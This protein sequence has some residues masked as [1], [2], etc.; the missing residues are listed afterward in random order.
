MSIFARPIVAPRRSPIASIWAIRPFFSWSSAPDFAQR[1]F[2]IGPTFVAWPA[3]IPRTVSALPFAF[4]LRETLARRRLVDPGRQHFQI[5]Q[6]L[7]LY[8][9]V[10]HDCFLRQAAE[11]VM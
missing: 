2:S 3:F 5:D 8:R 11:I 4:V 1:P 7:K 10:W 6:I 9:G